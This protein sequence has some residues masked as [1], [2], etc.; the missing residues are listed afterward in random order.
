[1]RIIPAEVV[2]I[3]MAG[4]N[5]L[6]LNP[7]IFVSVGSHRHHHV[8]VD[9]LAIHVAD[10]GIGIVV[11]A[12]WRRKDCAHEMLELTSGAL[13]RPRLAEH[14]QRGVAAPATPPFEP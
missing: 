6:H 4:P 11:R 9:A 3:A 2:E 12:A 8:D 1:M 5:E 10:A 7:G 13:A 14:P